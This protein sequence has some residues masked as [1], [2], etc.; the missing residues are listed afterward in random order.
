VKHPLSRRFVLRGAAGAAL[1]LPVLEA[2]SDN[3][4]LAD[5]APPKRFLLGYAG[6]SLGGS[7][8]SIAN[9]FVPT[10]EGANYDL[11][12]ALA[13][14]A[15]VKNEVTVVTG[16][17]IPWGT[18]SPAGGRELQFHYRSMAPLLT[19]TRSNLGAFTTPTVEHVAS[20]LL[21]QRN[22][23]PLVLR[24][25]AA[26]YD[27]S[28][29]PGSGSTISYRMVNGRLS[30]VPPRFSPQGTFQA[31]FGQL[32][33]NGLTPEQAA[34]QAWLL[35]NRKSVLDAMR[36]QYSSLLT[37]VSASDKQRLDDHLQEVRELEQRVAAIPPPQTA[38]CFRPMDPGA[39]P[40]I[41]GGQAIGSN[42]NITYS[43]NLGY[44]D[45]EQRALVMCD[46]VAMAITCDL[47]RS[48]SL[49]FSNVQCMMNMYSISG[50]LSDLHGLSHGSFGHRTEPDDTAAMAK[51]ISW[52]MKHWAR[53][54]AKLAAT[55]EGATSLLDNMGVCFVFEGGGG[56]DTDTNQA[57]G[58]H[59]TD[60]M[61]VL[62]SGGVGGLK[63]GHHLKATNLHPAQVLL[64]TLRA[65]GATSNS[66]GEVSGEIPGLRGP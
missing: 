25:Q 7:T 53:L 43:Q 1:S 36:S 66:L 40:S 4:A 37:R 2:M 47:T 45:E 51:G 22:F 64:T 12:T 26:S 16:L 63:R 57:K 18:T 29:Q 48:V 9:T 17:K 55:K 65:L 31:L 60:A 52:H 19:G 24:V 10:T 35:A 11:K 42:G 41:G 13:P 3:R 27:G 62:V 46:L 50:Q 33:T 6:T 8:G 21:G 38:T 59:S 39:D 14:L 54:L 32:P 49:Q 34:E 44:S 30:A 20:D 56:Y 5:A 23:S 58:P 61:A 28:A 15:P